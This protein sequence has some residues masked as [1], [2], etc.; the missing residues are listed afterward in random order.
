MVEAAASD[1]LDARRAAL[2][3]FTRQ[4]TAPC[5][6]WL[7][8]NGCG[9]EQAEETTQNFLVEVVINR[10]LLSNAR[11]VSGP[12]RALVLRALRNHATDLARRRSARDRHEAAAAAQQ[13]AESEA[14]QSYQPDLGFDA[15]WARAQLEEAIARGCSR[16]LA[17]GKHSAW[18]AFELRVLHPAVHGRLEPEYDEVAREAG[19]IDAARARVL[20][21]EMRMLVLSAL[22]EVVSETAR[23]PAEVEAEI[24]YIREC[25]G[26]MGR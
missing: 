20:V 2:D 26:A 11:R 23:E 3:A 7:R 10:Q 19:L 24:A 4:Y 17:L 1:D 15:D 16:A 13:A 21:R 8:A 6:S 5:V 9:A 22:D 25:L 14:E 12:L 18:R